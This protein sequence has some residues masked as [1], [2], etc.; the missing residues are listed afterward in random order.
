MVRYYDKVYV[1]NAGEQTTQIS[2]ASLST[3]NLLPTYCKV[4]QNFSIKTEPDVTTPMADGSDNVGSNA[5]N[6]E[7][8]LIDFEDNYADIVVN[9]L[10]KRVDVAVYD[11][12][13]PNKGYVVYGVQLFPG[14][15][16]GTN[17]ENTLKL[18]GKSRYSSGLATRC[19]PVTLT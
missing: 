3:W 2:R 16:I 13:F 15:D 19:S 14:L 10:N 1:R 4:T 6:V 7:L 17:K 5:A 18:T 8:E 12:N 9:F 11:S